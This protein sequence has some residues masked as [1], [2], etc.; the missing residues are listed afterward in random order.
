MTGHTAATIT[1]SRE[2]DATTSLALSFLSNLELQPLGCCHLRSVWASPSYFNF[3]LDLTS[4]TLPTVHFL[5]D[6]SPVKL[7]MTINHH[8]PW[9][10]HEGSALMTVTVA[11]RPHLW[12]CHLGAE[13]FNTEILK[14][15][16]I[17]LMTPAIP[18]PL[19]APNVQQMS[20]VIRLARLSFLKRPFSAPHLPFQNKT[21][22]R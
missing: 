15:Q 3:S 17:Q 19:L 13:D 4:Q 6:L 20:L 1:K 18:T 12:C 11:S 21:T 7:I 2:M 8:K 9:S 14:R 5:H 10:I 22:G 16:R